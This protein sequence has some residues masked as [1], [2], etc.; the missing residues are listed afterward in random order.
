MCTYLYIYMYIVY[1]H[2]TY[3]YIYVYIDIHM[4]GIYTHESPGVCVRALI[5]KAALLLSRST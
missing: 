5:V 3:M 1:I 4:Y 2:I